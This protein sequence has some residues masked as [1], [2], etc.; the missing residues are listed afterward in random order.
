[1]KVSFIRFQAKKG[2]I[3]LILAKHQLSHAKRNDKI[4]KNLRKDVKRKNAADS[5]DNICVII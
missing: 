5:F 2:G 4:R 3:V 1:M